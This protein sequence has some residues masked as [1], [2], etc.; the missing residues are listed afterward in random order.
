[1]EQI[2]LFI[3]K[4]KSDSELM[5]KL[6]ALGKS[7]AG[8]KEVVALAS[9]YGF[10]VTNEDV[11]AAR[12]QNYPHRGELSE[13]DLNNVSGGWSQDRYNPTECAKYTERHYWCVGFLYGCWCDHYRQENEQV[14]YLTFKVRHYCV[15]GFFDYEVIDY[16]R[17][18]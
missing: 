14:D 4:A 5:A 2:K 12:R 11:E 18:G 10:T 6:D 13:E 9:E 15:R 16:V 17:M 7:G 8:A 3:E 1:M